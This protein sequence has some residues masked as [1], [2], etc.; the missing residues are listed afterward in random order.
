MRMRSA[1]THNPPQPDVEPDD[2]AWWVHEIDPF[3]RLAPTER[4]A[5]AWAARQGWLT[6]IEAAASRHRL[7]GSRRAADRTTGRWL[8]S[9]PTVRP[10]C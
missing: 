3:H 7:A 1:I 4:A 2:F 8:T 5:R 6:D 10:A 9:S